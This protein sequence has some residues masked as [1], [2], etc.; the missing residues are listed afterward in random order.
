[1]VGALKWIAA[2]NV[3]FLRLG[4]AFF[5][6][7]AQPLRYAFEGVMANELHGFQAH[8][9]SFVPSGPGYEGVSPLN[10]VCAVVGS[11][12]G[13]TYVEGD[14]YLK[15]AF[16]YSYD[17]LWKVSSHSSPR[18]QQPNIFGRRTLVS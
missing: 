16:G 8:C 14:V 1:M 4:F 3:G 6:H 18:D 11:T 9:I 10:Q 12:A 13:Q 17:N 15:L 5:V 2:I 7:G